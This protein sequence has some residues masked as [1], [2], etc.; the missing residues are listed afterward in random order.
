V[1]CGSNRTTTVHLASW[2][3]GVDAPQQRRKATEATP[4]SSG[5]RMV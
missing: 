1:Q 5:K 2:H 4:Q 3:V